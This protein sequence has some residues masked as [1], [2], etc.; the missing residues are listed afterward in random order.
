MKGK[1]TISK[2]SRGTVTIVLEDAGSG[3]ALEAQMPPREFADALFGLALRP[4]ELSVVGGDVANIGKRKELMRIAAPMPDHTFKNRDQI[5]FKA[6]SAATPEGWECSDYFGSQNSFF[7]KN[8]VQ[9]A[10]ASAV[11]WVEEGE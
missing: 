10:R 2:D 3:I 1:L 5:A 9:H 4:C 11:R 6:C 8:G 7:V